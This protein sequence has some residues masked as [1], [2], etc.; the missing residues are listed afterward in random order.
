MIVTRFIHKNILLSV[1]TNTC[2]VLF[3]QVFFEGQKNAVNRLCKRYKVEDLSINVHT[4]SSYRIWIL[5]TTPSFIFFD[6]PYQQYSTNSVDIVV[7]RTL[8]YFQVLSFKPVFNTKISWP[9][10]SKRKIV[11]MNTWAISG[12]TRFG[13]S[14][15]QYR[16]HLLMKNA[17]KY[18]GKKTFFWIFEVPPKLEVWWLQPV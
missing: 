10:E 6:H 14:I 9:E 17:I 18:C 1:S 13:S 8:T 16:P 11:P 4:S 2:H 5:I 12:T 7:F 15:S 3:L